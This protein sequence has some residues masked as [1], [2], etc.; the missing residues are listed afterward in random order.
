M[1][2]IKNKSFAFAFLLLL[3]ASSASM[4]QKTQTPPKFVG[5]RG[6]EFV[7][8]GGKPI[9]LKG[10]NL[11]NW[12]LPEGY[13]FDFKKANSAQMIYTVFNQLVG[14]AEARKFWKQFQDTY[15]THEDI[16]FIK[17]SGFNSVRVPFSYRLFVSA[18]AR[19]Q[20][21]RTAR[22]RR[23]MVQT[24]RFIRRSRYARR[25]RRTDGRQY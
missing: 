20:R 11:G 13:M 23:W 6:K 12:L 21:L 9:F 14:E 24:G 17:K 18:K 22:T 5:V 10:I 25:A 2:L 8:P 19:R 15:I 16:K 7:L 3:L 1:K 4:A